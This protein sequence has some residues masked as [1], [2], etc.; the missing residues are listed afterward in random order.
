MKLWA[1]YYKATIMDMYAPPQIKIHLNSS[2]LAGHER[3]PTGFE[4]TAGFR[5]IKSGELELMLTESTK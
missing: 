3:S 2:G 4:R 5:K 1:G